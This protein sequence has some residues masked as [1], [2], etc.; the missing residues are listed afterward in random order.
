ML[1]Y[2]ECMLLEYKIDFATASFY[3]KLSLM[4]KYYMLRSFTSFT[5]PITYTDDNICDVTTLI[6]TI[7]V[8]LKGR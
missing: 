6:T 3:S 1:V 5:V 8:I 7:K 2:T 4:R